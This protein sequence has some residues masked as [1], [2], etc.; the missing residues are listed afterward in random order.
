MNEKKV[1]V[2]I[3]YLE[4]SKYACDYGIHI[5]KTLNL[6]LVLLNVIEHSHLPKH[7]NLAGNIGIGSQEN[8]L[9]E[10]ATQEAAE[11]KTSIALGKKMLQELSSLAKEQG[12]QTVHTLQRHGTLEETLEELSN[13][14]KIAVI[15][16]ANSATTSTNTLVE[17]HVETVVRTLNIPIL[18]V[19]SPFKPIHSIL[20]AYDGSSFANKAILTAV[21]SPI[22]PHIKRHVVTVNKEE[23][24]GFQ[25]LNEAVNIFKTSSIEVCPAC[26]QGE[27]VEALLDYQ[28]KHHLDLIAMGAYSHN[29]FSSALFGSLTS[30]MILKAPT[31]LLLFR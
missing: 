13:D 12:I 24:I 27:T 25:L 17:S 2:C 19:K 3:D 28:K 9:K 11:S 20:M 10:L 4:H 14:L 7:V 22:F 26:V 8:L 1:L 6:P 29:R 5:A 18:L 16:L 31:P 30:K 15:P 23:K 21:K